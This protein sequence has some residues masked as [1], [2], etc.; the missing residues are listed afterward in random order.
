[1]ELI[2]AYLHGRYQAVLNGGGI[3]NY[4]IYFA[5]N[6]TFVYNGYATTAD[7][8]YNMYLDRNNS[9]DANLHGTFTVNYFY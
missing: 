9:I 6:E 3:T 8:A 2:K 7:L 4:P 1:M 5:F